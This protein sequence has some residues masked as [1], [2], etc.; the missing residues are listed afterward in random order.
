MKFHS[1]LLA[2]LIFTAPAFA[3]TVIVQGNGGPGTVQQLPGNATVA[4]GGGGPSGVYIQNNDN[5]ILYRAI[6][7]RDRY[8]RRGYNNVAPVGSVSAA[9]AGTDRTVEYNRCMREAIRDQEKLQRKYN[10]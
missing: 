9:C 1:L 6:V 3:E 10:D 7:G 5:D 2:G 8:Y 4:T